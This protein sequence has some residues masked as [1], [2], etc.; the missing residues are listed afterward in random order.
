MNGAFCLTSAKENLKQ[1]L[2]TPEDKY[3]EFELNRK[4]LI[5]TNN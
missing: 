2:E 1:K 3:C 4:K 5:A